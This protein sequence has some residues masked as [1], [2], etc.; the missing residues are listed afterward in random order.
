M[1]HTIHASVRWVR[2]YFRN[3]SLRHKILVF[4]MA[5]ILLVGAIS[6]WSIQ[7]LNKTS[8]ELLH[9]TTASALSYASSSIADT[10]DS[11]VAL[12]GTIATNTQL[13]RHLSTL[14]ET[15]LSS[16][17]RNLYS[18]FQLSWDNVS[19]PVFPAMMLYFSG[20]EMSASRHNGTTSLPDAVWDELEKAAVD[21]A[22]GPAFVTKYSDEYGIFLVR[23]IRRI[24]N[25]KLDHLGTL[26][27]QIDPSVLLQNDPRYVSSFNNS[28]QVLFDEQVI[29]ET[30]TFS[31]PLQ[32]D[33]F[34]SGKDYFL[35]D[36]GKFFVTKSSIPG[37]DWQYGIVLDYSEMTSTL[38][39]ARLL[40]LVAICLCILLVVLL[41]NRA[42][43]SLLYHFDVLM[44]KM[45]S[46]DGET[47][48][49][50]D[51]PVY[52]YSKR[53]DELG[54]LHQRFDAMV[55]RIQQLIHDNYLKELLY[56]EARL[57]TLEAQLDPHFL[58][59]TLELINWQA[60]VSHVPQISQIAESLGG[61]LRVVLDKRTHSIPLSREISLVKNYLVIQQY[62]F[63]DRL[64]YDFAVDETLLDI[65][66]PKLIIQPLV[67]NAVRYGLERTAGQCRIGIQ[68]FL[69]EEKLHIIV[70]NTNS[71]FEDDILEKLKANAVSPSGF[72]IGI[73]NIY[74]RLQLQ[75]Q[76]DSCM[77]FG[78]DDGCA[79]VEITIPCKE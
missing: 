56:T 18:V 55:L 2:E 36:N 44:K 21:A 1:K 53:K 65:S 22:G 33:I 73:L 17:Y 7:Q 8:L 19:Q 26:V 77:R 43:N 34:D 38:S 50:C 47:Y 10:L 6:I 13:Q 3:A 72:G 12:T 74:Q 49:C 11:A 54:L 70:K 61:M 57:K 66:I 52:D 76:E 9:S 71:A 14:Q 64:Q 23:S 27:L 63:E 67:E 31:R 37:Y 79:T 29:F 40:S 39:G 20:Y 42:I 51:L 45:A 62:R 69:Q 30:S 48:N 15:S 25:L 4:V 60:K 75:Y 16:A 24:E 28:A 68:V 32:A 5:G 46:F 78:N 59:N 41:L 35:T 58:Y